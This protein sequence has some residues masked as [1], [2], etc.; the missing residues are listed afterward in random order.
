MKQLLVVAALL[1]SMAI[2]P[3]YA[4]DKNNHAVEQAE[5]RVDRLQERLESDDLT[6]R[7][8]D[9]IEDRVEAI[10][11]KFDIDLPPPDRP[12]CNFDPLV[13]CDEQ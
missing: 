12:I 11:E 1:A 7:Q 6:D 3:A 8:R 2:V 10:T 9:Q 13:Y 4:K 5:E